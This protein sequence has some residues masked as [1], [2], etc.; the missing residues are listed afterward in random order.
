MSV[1]EQLQPGEIY[2][3]IILDDDGQAQHHLILLPHTPDKDI[4]WNQAMEWAKSVNGELPTRREQSLLFANAGKHFENRWHW[5]C[6]QNAD[7]PDYA[8]LQHFDY[9]HQTSSRKSYKCRARSVRRVLINATQDDE[10]RGKRQLGK[11]R[12][13]GRGH[14]FGT[15]E[16]KN[17]ASFIPNPLIEAG[18]LYAKGVLDALFLV[19]ETGSF[20]P[21]SIEYVLKHLNMLEIDISELSTEKRYCFS[22][23]AIR[24]NTINFKGCCTPFELGALARLRWK[25]GIKNNPYMPSIEPDEHARWEEGF[26][27]AAGENGR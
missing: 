26:N 6:A 24:S 8:W 16:F 23:L 15:E 20:T 27:D 4:N 18:K 10:V 17:A 14:K 1:L 2:A 19:I 25:G 3:G 11:V 22:R 9:G 7:N 5:S 12:E 13:L 21:L